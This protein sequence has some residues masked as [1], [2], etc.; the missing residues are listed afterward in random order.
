MYL[1]SRVNDIFSIDEDE[2]N[3][4]L[5]LPP[6][7]STDVSITIT[8]VF[9]VP[10]CIG[11][12]ENIYYDPEAP[13]GLN[14]IIQFRYYGGV[15]ADQLYR[16]VSM[17]I[18]VSVAPSLHCHNYDVKSLP[19]N[20]TQCLVLFDADNK[21]SNDMELDYRVHNKQVLKVA[22][23]Q[24]FDDVFIAKSQPRAIVAAILAPN[25]R[26][27]LRS[28]LASRVKKT[29]A[30]RCDYGML[31]DYSDGDG[32]G[33]G[34]NDSIDNDVL[35]MK[36]RLCMHEIRM[37]LMNDSTRQSDGSVSGHGLD[38]QPIKSPRNFVARDQY[39]RCC[40]F[41]SVFPRSA[42]VNHSLSDVVAYY[43]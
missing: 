43:S 10:M 21:T 8:G 7:E 13:W 12:S 30:Y 9:H 37:A 2:L 4:R 34:D 29:P 24:E 19:S 15:G 16:R 27:R 33:D 36:A 14:G 17:T 11:S 1:V 3:S 32:D 6:G 25:S 22:Y 28:R 26:W 39:V 40:A 5:P 38:H 35:I 18:D 20:A 41:A 23:I 31:G 42:L